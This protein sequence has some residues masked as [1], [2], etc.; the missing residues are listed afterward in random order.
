[1]VS[2]VQLDR[3]MT[4]SILRYFKLH[5]IIHSIYKH[6]LHLKSESMRILRIEKTMRTENLENHKNVEKPGKAWKIQQTPN[7]YMPKS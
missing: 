7:P 3:K 6:S 4:E 5:D 1:M 2:S